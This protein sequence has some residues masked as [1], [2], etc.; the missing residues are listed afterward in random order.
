M[1]ARAWLLVAAA[2]GFIGGNAPLNI[3][4]AET[5]PARPVTMVIPLGAG[6]GLDILGRILTPRLSEVL[7]QQVV[8]ENVSGAGGMTGAARVARAAPD[9]YQFLL[10]T[11][12]TH[13]QNQPS[14]KLHCTTLPLTSRQSH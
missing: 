6:S 1:S 7:G 13:A 5:W 12:G 14:I 11:V 9:G 4:T 2:C 3:A 10:G 8:V